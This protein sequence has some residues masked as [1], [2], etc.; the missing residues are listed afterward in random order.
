MT[1]TGSKEDTRIVQQLLIAAGHL[2]PVYGPEAGVKTSADGYV[3]RDTALAIK[4]FQKSVLNFERPD[5]LIEPNG[6]TWDK[7]VTYANQIPA[8][9]KGEEKASSNSL[10]YDSFS[11]GG[12]NVT[13]PKGDQ[14]NYPIVV[15]FG[16]IRY[17]TKEWMQ[18]QVP[19]PMF[20]NHIFVFAS[21]NQFYSSVGPAHK[22]ILKAQGA[23][24]SYKAV[25]GFSGGGPEA[26][27]AA[28]QESWSLIGLIDPA[29]SNP[30][31]NFSAPAYMNWNTWGGNLQTDPRA[32]FHRR[33]ER[34][35]IS[36]QSIRNTGDHMNK[37]QDWFMRWGSML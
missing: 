33:F 35:E 32:K 6:L 26:M 18:K 22:Q 34:G 31:A 23:G 2:A 4:S 13:I 25:L 5:G 16:G 19:Y 3:G 9:A 11:G 30:N 15:I 36:G 1:F 21:H 12:V 29:V 27:D 7:L 8:S 20:S 28:S 24:G 14:K 10:S 37:P 17:A